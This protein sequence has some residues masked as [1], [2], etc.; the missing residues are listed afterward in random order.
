MAKNIILLNGVEM[1]NKPTSVK[2]GD[3]V[4]IYSTGKS[5]EVA[6]FTIEIA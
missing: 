6:T 4:A 5:C 3:K 2:N 1:P